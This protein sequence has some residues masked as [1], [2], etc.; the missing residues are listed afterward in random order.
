MG[1]GPNLAVALIDIS[2]DGLGVRLK[3]SLAAGDEVSVELSA[4]GVRKSLKMVGDIRWCREVGD[5]TFA[6]GVRLRRRLT[7]AQL[8]D[9]TR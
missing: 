1:L 5:G 3:A 8:N 4:P 2:E 6:A 9:M 7:Y